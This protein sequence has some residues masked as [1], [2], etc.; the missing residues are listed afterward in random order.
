[1]KLQRDL[2]P[3]L[4]VVTAYGAGYV[5]ING[6]R[7]AQS[8]VLTPQHVEVPW[9]TAG[10]DDLQAEDFQALLRFA[11]EI[12]LFG[13][14]LKQRFAP[15]ALMQSLMQARIGI[16]TMDTFAA[17]RT[18]NILVAEGRPVMAALLIE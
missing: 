4:N 6:Q 1:M 12:L 14:G 16:E 11:P 3:G 17:C 2:T 15:P 8:L 18:Y 9:T 5:D 10:F 13:S 7:H